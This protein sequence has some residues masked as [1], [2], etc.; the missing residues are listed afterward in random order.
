MLRHLR[1]RLF[2]LPVLAFVG[3]G[4]ESTVEA[5]APDVSGPCDDAPAPG[6]VEVVTRDAPATTEG[7][8]FDAAGRL[9]VSTSKAVYEVD[10]A[11]VFTQVGSLPSALGLHAEADRL[12]VAGINTG[13]LYSLTPSSGVTA[14]VAA[15]LGQPN[16]VVAGPRGGWLVADDFTD[17]ISEVT[18]AGAAT[19]YTR[20]VDSPNGMAW[21]PDG[22]TLYIAS[23]FTDEALW[24]LPIAADGTPDDAAVRKVAALP[25]GS[26]PDGITISTAGAVYVALNTMGRIARIAPDGTLDAAF[27]E[28]LEFPASLGIARGG[29]FDRCSLWVSSLLTRKIFRV[30]LAAEDRAGE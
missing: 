16:F 26:T 1:S 21:A 7:L 3:I 8:V 19:I 23:T 5:L 29:A 2:L 28:G 12:L 25:A 10:P 9:Y 15:G 18:A 4:C 24:A 30:G 14:T 17:R 20:A 22:R 27:A 6:E 13:E 11:G